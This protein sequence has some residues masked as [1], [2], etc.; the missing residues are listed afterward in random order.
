MTVLPGTEIAI[1]GPLTFHQLALIIGAGS[2][3]IAILLSLYLIMMH[4]TH[5]T[6][7]VEANH[8]EGGR[9]VNGDHEEDAHDLL[10]FVGDCV[11]GCV[12]YD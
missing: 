1:A 4:A 5:Y 3:L 12:H 8:E 7:P 6:V 2:A 10:L 11:V 9:R